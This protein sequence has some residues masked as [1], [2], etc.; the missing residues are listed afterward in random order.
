MSG[1]TIFAGLLLGVLAL[2]AGALIGGFRARA[3]SAARLGALQAQADAAQAALADALARADQDRVQLNAQRDAVDAQRAALELEARSAQTDAARLEAMLEAERATAGDRTAL[4]AQA[5]AQLREAFGAL[6]AEALRTNNESFMQ[7]AESRFG[8]VSAAASGELSQRQQAIEGLVAPLRETL[9]KVQTQLGEAERTR[10]GSHAA[11]QEQIGA[12]R[13]SSEQLRT[14]TAQLVTALRAPQVRG[15]WGELQ[16]ERALESSGM[17]E[18]VDYDTQATSTSDDGTVRPDAVVH[19]PGGK[20]VV[21]DSKV[22]FAGY[23]E[24]M[25]ARDEATRAARLKAHARHMREHIDSLAAKAY[26]ERFTPAPEFVVC[27]VPADAF[28][29]AALR[30]DPSLLDHAFARNV[31][32]ATP[33]TLIAL[34]R[35]VAYTWRQEALAA[36][37]AEV[38]KLGRELYQRLSTMGGHIDKLGKRLGDAVGAYNESVRSLDS[39]VMVTARKL[40]DLKVVEPGEPLSAG[41][42]VTELPGSSQSPELVEQRVVALPGGKG[43]ARGTREASRSAAGLPPITGQ[44][45]LLAAVGD[46]RLFSPPDGSEPGR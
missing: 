4:L 46:D 32:V 44:E 24:A 26:W 31:V 41:R 19:L 14:E 10:A 2:A 42:Q 13:M 11:L 39:R 18:H 15:R 16:L 25:E 35:T 38:H 36:N 8:Q 6:S 40:V 33:S 17:V 7:L 3:K 5:Q 37:A 21:L 45:D 34:L 43:S 22:A 20:N 28:L 27:F 12:M 1:S 30:E 23:L 29:D 9:G